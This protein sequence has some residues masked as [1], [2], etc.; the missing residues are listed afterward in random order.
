MDVPMYDVYL[1][2]KLAADLDRPVAAERLAQ[3]F[4]STP[5]TM[6]GLLS[7]KPQLL[8]RGVDKNTA[9]KYRDTL[10]NAGVEVAFKAQTQAAPDNVATPAA[11]PASIQNDS[12][13]HEAAQIV[14]PQTVSGSLTLAPVGSNVLNADEQRQVSA[15]II[16]LSHLTVAAPGP[17]LDPSQH[18]AT[19]TMAP[20]VDHLTLREAGADLL[21]AAERAVIPS[22]MPEVG[23]YGLAPVGAPLETLHEVRAA[24]EV[25]I[26]QL[27]LAPSGVD[28]LTPEQ[29]HKTVTAAPSTDHIKLL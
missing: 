1:T 26:S 12:A 17:L 23:D 20:N 13:Q 5:A 16:D 19:D 8:K 28:L 2:G 22:A 25:D 29:R 3:I 18:H 21:T 27:S 4:K 24:V 15:A 14:T 7:G 10:Q 11:A 6:L 9:L